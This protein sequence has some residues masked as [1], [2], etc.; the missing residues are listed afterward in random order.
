MAAMV[1]DSGLHSGGVQIGRASHTGWVLRTAGLVGASGTA[2]LLVAVAAAFLW[3]Y[4]G[5]GAVRLHRLSSAE[6]LAVPARGSAGRTDRVVVLGDSVGT[7]AGCGCR[8]FGPRLARLLAG[9]LS[10]PVRVATLARDGLTSVGLVDQ[11]EHD[12]GTIEQLRAA[13]VVTVVIGAN[14]FDADTVKTAHAGPGSTAYQGAF[15]ALPMTLDAALGRIRALTGARARVLVIGYWNVF[16][17]G[18]VGAQHGQTYQLISDAVTRRVDDAL[19]Q[20]ATRAGATYVDLY[21]AFH[22]GVSRDDTDLLAPDGDHPSAVGHERIAEL[23]A[24]Y[25]DVSAG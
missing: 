17:D 21:K 16:L 15:T 8:P 7:G 22:A 2:C 1:P 19:L 3:P 4:S 20:S 23:L 9:R 12:K 6:V 18:A 24:G 13:D 5:V 11:V 14:D 10:Q 25:V